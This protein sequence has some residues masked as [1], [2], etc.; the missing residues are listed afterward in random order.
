[1]DRG[2]VLHI[3][4]H[5][6]LSDAVKATLE[7]YSGNRHS[8]VESAATIERAMLLLGQIATG[9]LVAN[10]VLL[11]GNLSSGVHNGNDAKK[12][13]IRIAELGLSLKTIGMSSDKMS[14]YGITVDADLPKDK[15]S[16]T[17]LVEIIDNF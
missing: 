2:L 12:I 15:F 10:I 6:D 16:G 3:E 1:M 4:D 7:V 14:D 17:G 5:K 13:L 11:D 8:V 9:E